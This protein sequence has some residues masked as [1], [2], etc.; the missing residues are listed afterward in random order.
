[1]PS[2]PS[3]ST[4]STITRRQAA[5]VSAS[6]N[7]DST[8]TAG[9]DPQGQSYAVPV[10]SGPNQQDHPAVSLRSADLST[11]DLSYANLRGADLRGP[12][13]SGAILSEQFQRN[14]LIIP[15]EQ[16]K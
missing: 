3:G 15:D 7:I 2:Y 13:L 6:P 1:M 14:C 12:H 9:R 11:A 4:T 10:R 5:R 8:G 16:Q